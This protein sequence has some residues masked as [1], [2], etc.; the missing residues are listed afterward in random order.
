MELIMSHW[1]MNVKKSIFPSAV[2]VTCMLQEQPF[3]WW[4]NNLLPDM[5]Q[6]ILEIASNTE[7]FSLISGLWSVYFLG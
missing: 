1:Q 2:V 7:Y 4:K 6:E 3:G 5:P